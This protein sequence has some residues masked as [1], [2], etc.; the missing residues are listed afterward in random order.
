M[1]VEGPAELF[2]IPSLVKCVLKKDLDREGITVI[3]IHGTHFTAYA[4]LFGGGGIAKRC[5]IVTDGDSQN[6][7]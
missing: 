4:K 5:A 3:P 1:L 6:D 7:A 2:L